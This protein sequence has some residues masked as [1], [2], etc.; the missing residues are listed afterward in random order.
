MVS[1]GFFNHF[2]EIAIAIYDGAKEVVNNTADQIQLDARKLVPVE[3]GF[4]FDSIYVEKFSGSD[5]GSGGF[6]DL[7]HDLLPE[8]ETPKNEH[9]A[10]VAV[11][12]SYA[13]YVE[14]G[15]IHMAPQPFFYPAVDW[16]QG[17]LEDELSR[18]EGDLEAEFG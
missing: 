14:L 12:A 10:I 17:E 8:V 9:T 4:L 11:G 5:Y 1:S 7:H 16:G 2:P 13:G 18:L 3:T 15:T 6:G